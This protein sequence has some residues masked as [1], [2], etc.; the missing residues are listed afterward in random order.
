MGSSLP[1]PRLEDVGIWNIFLFG[2]KYFYNIIVIICYILAIKGLVAMKKKHLHIPRRVLW[3]LFLGI[4]VLVA[5]LNT[6]LVQSYLGAA[7][8][9]YFSKE[10][11][12]KV[13]IGTIHVNPFSHVMLDHIE[14]ISPTNDTIYMGDRITCRFKRFPLHKGGLKFDRVLLRNGRYHFESIKYPSGKAGINLDY[15][16]HYFAPQEP[17]PPSAPAAPFVV[18]VGEL[19]LRNIDYIMDLPEPEGYQK[20]EHGVDIPHM[21][22]KDIT[23]HFRKIRVD[24]DS[25]TCRIVSLTTTERSGLHVV[26]LSTDVEV[27]RHVIRAT[28]LDLQTADSRVFLDAQLLYHGWEAMAD[29]CRNVQHKVVLKEGTEVNLKDASY[30]APVLWGLNCKVA[31]QGRAYG[32][33]A[34]LNADNLNINF[35]KNSHLLVDGR[36]TGLPYIEQT[37]VDASV[38][39]LHTTYDDL[40]EVRFPEQ[41]NFELP[42]IARH[43]GIIDLNASAKGGM[44]NFDARFDIN[45]LIGDLEGNAHISYDS[46][47]NNYAYIGELD[48]KTLGIRSLLPNEWIS[49]TGMHLTF[50]GQSFD[51]M[52]ME[53]SVEGR[54]YN[55]NIRGNDIDRTT[56]SAEID[57]GVVAADVVLKDTLINLNLHASANLN[58]QECTAE[59]AMRNA[60]LSKL[61]LVTSDSAVTVST[62]VTANISSFDLE[63]L[64]G[65]VAIKNTDCTFGNRHFHSGWMNLT[66]HETDGYKTVELNSDLVDAALTGYF[67]IA[68]LPLVARD[69]CDRYIPMYYNPFRNAD[70]ADL[71]ALYEDQFNIQVRWLDPS[72]Q[73][74]QLV[75]GL[76]V[77]PEATFHGS[78]NYGESLRMVFVA[79]EIRYN[80]MSFNSIGLNTDAGGDHYHL[81]I[82]ASNMLLNDNE[83]IDNVQVNARLGNS[84]STLGLRWDDPQSQYN[85]N[86]DLEFFLTSTPTDN[87]LMITKPNFNAVRQKW[88]LS[89]PDGIWFNNDRLRIDNLKIYALG[90]SASVK[91]LIEGKD[92]D[93]V[94]VAFSD[95]VLSNICETFIPTNALTLSGELDGLFCLKGLHDT[96]HFD[97]NLVIE[98]CVINNEPAGRVELNSN[99]IAGEKKLFVDLVAQHDADGHHHRPIE[100]HGNLLLGDKTPKLDFALNLDEVR[101][102]TLR[103]TIAEVMSNIEGNVSGSINL[104]GTFEQPMLHGNLSISDGLLQL[105]PTGVTYYFNDSFTIDNNTLTLR[106]FAIHDKLANTI[107]ANGAL[108]LSTTDIVDLDLDVNTDRILLLDKEANESNGF[109]GKLLAQVK[110]SVKGPV[111]NLAINATASTLNGSDLYVPID[112]SKQVQENEFITFLSPD[113]TQ[114]PRTNTNTTTATPSNIDLRVNLHVTPGLKLHL[115]MDFDQ[116]GANVNAVG[117]GD[118]QVNIQGNQPPNIL[119]DYEFTSGNFSLSL[120]QLITRNF[121]I[122]EGSTLNFPGNINDARFNI[123]AVYN[124]RTNLATLMANNASTTNDSYVQI[125][126]VIQVSGTLQDPSIKFDIRVPNSEQSVSEQVFS[127]LDRNNELEMLN[128]SISLLV[129][130]QFTPTNTSSQG[131]GEGF[132]SVNLVAN[133]AGSII[134]SM[135]K[136][137]DVDF[138]YQASNSNLNPMGQFDVGISKSWNKFYFE[139]TFGYGNVNSMDIDQSNT[140]VG[141]VKVGYK[142]NP[143][144]NF[145]G[146]HRT[147]TSYYTRTE[148]PYKQGIGV[149][150]SKD[151]DNLRDLVPWLF[152][153]NKALPTKQTPSTPSF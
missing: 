57:K 14:L 81:Q 99:Y 49:R 42:A 105:V 41:A 91:A 103:P 110:G 102:Q 128:Q 135:V 27:S 130:G 82:K 114:R 29:Y 123:S 38:Q 88:K 54:L 3:S 68:D 101:L 94:K 72:N 89:C 47:I 24:A 58:S 112:N 35:S 75:P 50:Q 76:M 133:T 20:F 2:G 120:L 151:F 98:N 53:T 30:W 148:L 107:W 142:F 144:F 119:G 15:I 10:W 96:P 69:F 150:L 36:I 153:K 28:N 44:S 126:D 100:L 34:N 143:Y 134:T 23:G 125:Q 31:V 152:K 118:I 9:S 8:G 137:V 62:S 111:N 79:D 22:F 33:V 4:Y 56:L 52:E 40:A 61:H 83:F 51:P 132:N 116:L 55:T 18:E 13:R 16:I 43:L 39:N 127:Y 74:A 7:A 124:L 77:S 104:Q 45:S 86:D 85:I 149:E 138:K 37:T 87:R 131:G 70:S 95:F 5:L 115:P 67:G 6:S 63:H 17:Q 97:A 113:R 21:R 129:L 140:I 66:S 139:S 78:Y 32:P 117:R 1:F 19:R 80:S 136:V 147:N 11:G 92:D 93:F 65:T 121:T 73:L 25:I 109:F 60:Q 145:Y 64:A 59:F 90:Q 146:F 108:R 122:E 46:A 26:D 71:S 106:N 12:G 84:I 48:S 141:D